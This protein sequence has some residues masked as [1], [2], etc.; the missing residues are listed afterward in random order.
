[1]ATDN[2]NWRKEIF[3]LPSNHG[4]TA[5]PG[6][7]V[8]VA[9]RGAL[10]FEI[11]QEWLVE[12]SR[13]SVK[14]RDAEPPDDTM[15]LEVSVLYHGYGMGIDWSGLPLLELIK[16]VTDEN[17]TGR[18]GRAS[19]RRN[20]KG[21]DA[22]K[23]GAPITIKLGNLEM[24]WVESEFIDP[25]EK[26][27]AY[28]RTAITRDPQKSIHALLT[29]SYWPEDAERAKAVWNDVMGTLKMGDH[30]ESPFRGPDYRPG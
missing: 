4:W 24:A 26:R 27:P 30:F 11:P 17:F 14:F 1:M 13:K 18:P 6:N 12:P 5:K 25:G 8:F 21:R 29:F 28:S 3:N 22:P 2:E 20:R 9:D 16:N 23:V 15:G 7:K 10:R 19:R